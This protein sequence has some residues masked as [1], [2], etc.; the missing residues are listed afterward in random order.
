M[1]GANPYAI[2]PT[3]A[4]RVANLSEDQ[5]RAVVARCANTTVKRA[6]YAS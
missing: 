4:A 2:A 1:T 6:L 3:L 5:L